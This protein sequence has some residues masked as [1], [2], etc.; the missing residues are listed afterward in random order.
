MNPQDAPIPKSGAGMVSYG[1]SVL[2]TFAGYGV[3]P[4][5]PRTGVD[6]P[7]PDSNK[8]GWTN[9]LIIFDI[10]SS[11]LVVYPLCVYATLHIS[12]TGVCASWMD[13]TSG[14]VYYIFHAV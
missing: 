11:K 10:T 9:E 12:T 7:D 14:H 1:E 5:N 4:E 13:V 3:L 8:E 6:V 2:V